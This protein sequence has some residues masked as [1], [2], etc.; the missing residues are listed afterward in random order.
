MAPYFAIP[1]LVGI[2]SMLDNVQDEL[3]EKLRRHSTIDVTLWMR[4]FS[5]ESLYRIAFSQ[6]LGYL[7]QGERRRWD[8]PSARKF[9]VCVL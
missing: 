1:N 5:L 3:E 2:E 4:L 8:I 9:C 6:K 7:S